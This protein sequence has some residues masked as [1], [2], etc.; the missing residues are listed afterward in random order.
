MKDLHTHCLPAMD[1]G[2]KTVEE[3]IEMLCE[4]FKQGVTFCAATPHCILHEQSDIDVFLQKRE[5]R[6][7]LLK[8]QLSDKNCDV[9][10]LI[11]GAEIYFDNDISKYEG[12]E[13]LCLTD[14]NKILVEFPV[15]GYNKRYT[16]WLYN[17]NI[18]GLIP[19]IAHLDRYPFW[20]EVL[21]E[22][23]GLSIIYQI[24]D[25][26]MLTF[27]GRHFIKQALK[28]DAYCVFSSDMHNTVDRVS[29]MGKAYAKAKIH[30]PSIADG[31]FDINL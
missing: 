10:K 14:T 6:F 22:L 13:K 24:N 8:K 28:K 3:S 30:F 26:R 25:S 12:I 16:E 18:K 7:N 1:D 17:L 29:H 5:K 20:E 15:T 2:A 4:S 19:I 27:S 23:S 31:M 21:R 11:L 9:P